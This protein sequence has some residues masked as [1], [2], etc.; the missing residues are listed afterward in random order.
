[1]RQAGRHGCIQ[2]QLCTAANK[3]DTMTKPCRTAVGTLGNAQKSENEAFFSKLLPHRTSIFGC[4]I[5]PT[6]LNDANTACSFAV[7]MAWPKYL[8]V[9]AMCTCLLVCDHKVRVSRVYEASARTLVVLDAYGWKYKCRF[10]DV[11]NTCEQ[12]A[13]TPTEPPF[14]LK[15]EKRPLRVRPIEWLKL[16]FASKLRGASDLC[17]I[18]DMVFVI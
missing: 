18:H 17:F 9:F 13:A 3:T 2:N 4:H 10:D 5:Y 8:A 14:L 11:D 6:P 7:G 1:M 12:R 15:V 16:D